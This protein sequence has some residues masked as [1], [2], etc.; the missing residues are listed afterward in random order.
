MTREVH[1]DFRTERRAAVWPGVALMAAA[2]VALGAIGF[3]YHRV[4]SEVAAVEADVQAHA[5]VARKKP[6]AVRASKDPQ[7]VALEVKRAG[8]IA[9]ELRQPWGELFQSIESSSVPEVALL[10]IESDS[11]RRRV[12]ISAEGKDLDAVVA[13][14]RFLEGLPTLSG[15]YLE[16]HSVQQQ[17][18]QHPVRFVVAANWAVGRSAQSAARGL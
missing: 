16:S 10:G 11:G 15:V 12:K 7:L 5:A 18:P 8:E 6:L 13:Y 3:Q 2:L 17:D 1:L 4:V 9:Y 14:L